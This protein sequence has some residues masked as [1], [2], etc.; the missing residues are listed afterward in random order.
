MGIE[1]HA[2]VL[3]A[4]PERVFCD[5][6]VIGSGPGGAVTACALASAGRDVLVLEEGP[7]VSASACRPYSREEME[8]KYRNGGVTVGLGS[9]KVTYAEGC[10]VGGGS[11]VNA[12]LFYRAPGD[13]LERWGREYRIDG[14]AFDDLAP[15]FERI[16]KDLGVGNAI[17]PVS[18][19][20]TKLR[21]GASRLGFSSLDSPTSFRTGAEMVEADARDGEGSQR[22]SMSRTYL[23]WALDAGARLMPDTRA[24]TLVRS[25]GRWTVR[26]QHGVRAGSPRALEVVAKHV[27]V[28]GGAVQTP[29]LLRRSGLKRHVGDS[30]G[31]H[32]T[33]KITARFPDVIN[34]GTGGVPTWAIDEFAPRS[35]FTCAVSSREY[36]ALELL[37]YPDYFREIDSNWRRMGI[38]SARI[39]GGRGSVRNVPGFRDPL[40]YFRFSERDLAEL[41]QAAQQLGSCLFAAGAD[42]LFPSVLLGTPIERPEALFDRLSRLPRRATNLMTIH[43]FSSCPMGGDEN[44]CPADS[45]GGVRGA[46]G[47]H[48]ADA[49]LLCSA[50]TVNPQATIM[51]IARR[52]ALHFLGEL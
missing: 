50:P 11:E 51:A 8:R 12:G 23:R 39:S 20:S 14:I 25:A 15:H 44:R 1:G 46:P 16:E 38:Y 37:Q 48:I 18:P 4:S 28:A 10:C 45:F 40:V 27:F 9:P 7:L 33:L 41:S 36:V 13:V 43:L 24:R 34:E 2:G 47:L 35:Y 30:L 6:A 26:C 42:A 22:A 49:S 3:S 5:I 21:E 31:L 52:N 32:A 29:A 17:G 19:Q